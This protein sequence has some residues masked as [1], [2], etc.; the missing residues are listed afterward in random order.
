MGKRLANYDDME[1]QSIKSEL[2]TL[3]KRMEEVVTLLSGNSSYGVKGIRA[4]VKEVKEDVHKIKVEVEQLKK[5]RAFISFELK[6]LP[7]RIG[8]F[9]ILLGTIITIVKT[10]IDIGAGK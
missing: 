7:S 2:T 8:A 6:T 5:D 3:N 10:F 4:E 9:I 1:I